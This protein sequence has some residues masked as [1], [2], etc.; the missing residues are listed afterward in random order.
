MIAGRGQL[1]RLEGCS[2]EIVRAEIDV[3]KLKMTVDMCTNGLQQLVTNY[4]THNSD[5]LT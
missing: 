2:I 1:I 4:P 5:K 3:V